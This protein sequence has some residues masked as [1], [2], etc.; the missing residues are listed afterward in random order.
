MK[1]DAQ[2]DLLIYLISHKPDGKVI[3]AL[4]KQLSTLIHYKKRHDIG[5]VL[6]HSPMDLHTTI[7]DLN[8]EAS[9]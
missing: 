8:L 1:Y 3:I 7:L 6:L 5:H 4:R 2:R 9:K